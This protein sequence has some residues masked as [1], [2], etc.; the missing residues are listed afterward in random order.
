MGQ[1][2]ALIASSRCTGAH[3]NHGELAWLAAFQVEP[4]SLQFV[5]AAVVLGEGVIGSEWL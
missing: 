3:E 1:T 5:G 2:V 4:W